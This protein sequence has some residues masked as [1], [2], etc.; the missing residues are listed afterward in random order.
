[1][2]LIVQ[3]Y[4]GTSVATTELIMKVAGRVEEALKK[5]Y[6]VVVVV[7]AMGKETDR[8]LDLAYEISSQPDER[9]LDLLLSSGERVSISLLTIALHK[10][11]IEALSFTGRQVGIITDDSHTRARIVDI[12]GDRLRDALDRGEVAVVAG[13]QGMNLE[14]DVT[15]LGRGGSD[16][17]AVALA[18]AL[19]AELCEIYTDVE[20]VFTAD[21]S[22]VDTARR[23]EKIS[24]EEM[25]ELASMGARILH[26]RSVEY[27]M[28]N[29]VPI[30]VRSTFSQ[31]PGTLVTQEEPDMEKVLVS[32]VT[33]A[34]DETKVTI[35]SVPDK[36]GVAARIFTPLSESGVV[37]DMIVQNISDDGFTDL[38]FTVPRG[39]TEKARDVL[40]PVLEDIGARTIAV[41]ESLAK[42][43]I[44]GTGMRTH[45]GVAA[46][47]FQIMASE[48][49]NIYMISTSEIKISCMIEAKYA[50]LA[51]RVLHD[52]FDLGEPPE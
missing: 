44:V 34:K 15:T 29:R 16:L 46:R 11:G 47:M 39:D 19:G 25:L 23:L 38:T 21:P 24:Y 51:L 52:A 4:G 17:T 48:G 32:G 43:S 18:G 45:A 30:R 31:D 9:E 13:F 8:L 27:A 14:E 5:G 7:S 3:K 41:D 26:T 49:I 37:V 12:R 1:M 28:N 42:V 20:G 2:K 35:R 40:E 50:E 6:R 22:V 36:P 33:V 10:L